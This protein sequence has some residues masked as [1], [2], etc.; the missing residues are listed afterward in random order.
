[1]TRD[2][3]PHRRT[4]W[5][6]TSANPLV[7]VA[8]L[9]VVLAVYLVFIGIRGV[10]L[11]GQDRLVLKMLGGA[12]LV[13]PLLGIWVVV[14]ELRFGAASQRLGERIAAEGDSTALPGLP[15]RASGRVDRAAT[16]EWFAVQR[17][18]V[19]EEPDDWT[20]WYR[21]AQAYDLAGDRKRARQSLR[22]A[23]EL[24]G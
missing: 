22:R 10:Y 21:L 17:K 24:A 14:A 5:P 15:R 19:V 20:R 3:P 23:I 6:A 16:D 2:R 8:T 12:V 11:I 18:L 1:V 4:G 13:L 9:V 7:V